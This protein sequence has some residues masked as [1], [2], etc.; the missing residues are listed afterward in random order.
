MSSGEYRD[1]PH[2]GKEIKAGAIKCKHCRQFVP[3]QSDRPTVEGSFR[4]E[5]GQPGPEEEIDNPESS[6]H[7]DSEPP[8]Y[9]VPNSP[10]VASGP[11]PGRRGFFGAL[12]DIGMKDM[13]TPRIIRAVYLVGLILIALGL[14][15]SIAYSFLGVGRTGVTPVL[16][17]LLV[18]P[19][20]AVLSV[21]LLR[22]YLELVIL[23]FNIYDQL[24][25]LK[26]SIDR[27]PAE[28]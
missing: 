14:V 19:V 28:R 23:L 26:A 1:C 25:D 13:I 27:Q 7:F 15:F 17:T 18:A 5:P 11:E 9:H 3:D 2:C 16:T 24:R 22:V 21:L 12:F 8:D 6:P 10:S 4:D 20:A